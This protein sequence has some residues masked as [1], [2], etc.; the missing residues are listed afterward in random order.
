MEKV[1]NF[2]AYLWDEQVSPLNHDIFLERD[3]FMILRRS[4][5]DK[6]TLKA[7]V[8]IGVWD[9]FTPAIF[10]PVAVLFYSAMMAVNGWLFEQAQGTRISVTCYLINRPASR[11]SYLVFLGF[12]LLHLFFIL[13][14]IL[15]LPFS[16]FPKLLLEP[17]LQFFYLNFSRPSSWRSYGSWESIGPTRT[18]MSSGSSFSGATGQVHLLWLIFRV[19]IVVLIFILILI[20]V[21]FVTL[22]FTFCL[23]FLFFFFV[24][25]VSNIQ[26]FSLNSLTIF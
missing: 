11:F 20:F 10:T 1:H 7:D 5:F 4:V 13:F 18:S 17:M 15:K 25:V 19:F 9:S 8:A 2:I 14:I 22:V 3:V 6:I 26:I 16:Y 12:L 24:V 21:K 23:I